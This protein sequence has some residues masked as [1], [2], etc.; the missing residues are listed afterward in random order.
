MSTEKRQYNTV[1]SQAK[2]GVPG[3]A[4]AY[5]KFIEKATIDQSSK[6]LII[7][8]SRSLAYVALHFNRAPHLISVEEINSYL[9]RMMVHEQCSLTYFKHAVFALRYWFRLF[10]MEDKA[11]QMPPV[12]KEKKLPVVLSKQECKE[13]FRAP[14]NLKHRFLLAFAYAGGLRMNELRMLK[15]TDIDVQRNQVFIRNGKGRKQRYVGLSKFI[16]QKLP[17]YFK[18]INPRLYLFEG[19]TPG[20]PM[21][22]RSIQYIITEALQKT[23]IQKQVSMHTL[24]HSYATHLLEDG[25]DIHTIQHLLGH[26]DLQTTLVYL[27]VAQVKI[28]P[29]HSPL[30]SLYNI[31]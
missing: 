1:V 23:N 28:K 15:I 20:E 27:H 29:A 8:Y 13:L 22:E 9:Y 17:F 10:D 26:A 4:I 6:S 11:I 31:V 2:K 16:A 7:N 19:L 21:G 30:D 3:F 5:A 14:R 12:K 24:R 18:E 25:I